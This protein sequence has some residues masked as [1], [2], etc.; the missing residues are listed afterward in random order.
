[1]KPQK[2]TNYHFM[3]DPNRNT[4]ALYESMPTMNVEFETTELMTNI[5]GEVI[6]QLIHRLLQEDYKLEGKD[7]AYGNVP[8]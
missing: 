1:M 5:P 7:K 8:E 6:T 3:H 2:E 4:Y